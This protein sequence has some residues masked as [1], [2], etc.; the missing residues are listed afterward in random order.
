VNRGHRAIGPPAAAELANYATSP[1]WSRRWL[2]LA[3]SVLVVASPTSGRLPSTRD[4]TRRV[5]LMGDSL[6]AQASADIT[7]GLTRDGYHVDASAAYPGAGL[8]DTR[9]DWLAVAARLVR[10]ENPAMAVVEY[11]GNYG[12]YG[13]IPGVRVYSKSFY[14]RWATAAQRLEDILASRGARVYWV[15]G[16]PVAPRAAE[17]G[18]VALDHIYEHLHRPGSSARPQLINVT[19]ALS[20]GTG[21]YRAFLRGPGGRLV[22]VRQP[23]GVHLTSAGEALFARAVLAAL[24]ARRS[25]G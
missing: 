6:L 3:L 8:L 23:D 7:R 2:A 4:T 17:A 11:V 21:H 16:P 1:R 25:A 15:I 12:V 9:I 13:S 18:I 24:I 19:P 14:A 20:G 5:V 22:R 10:T